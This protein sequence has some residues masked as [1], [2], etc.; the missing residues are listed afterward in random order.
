MQ[1]VQARLPRLPLGLRGADCARL[2]PGIGIDGL[3]RPLQ[4]LE[5]GSDELTGVASLLDGLVQLG[6]DARHIGERQAARHPLYLVCQARGRI[7]LVLGYVVRQHGADRHVVIAKTA[8][9]LE[10]DRCFAPVAK[11]GIDIDAGHRLL[12]EWLV[13]HGERQDAVREIA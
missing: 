4:R 6:A 13:A 7:G 9:I 1:G 3:L 2:A 12:D 10:I 5:E 11:S 8:Q